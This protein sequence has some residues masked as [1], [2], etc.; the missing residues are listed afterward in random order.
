MLI[1]FQE[2]R[3]RSFGNLPHF[4]FDVFNNSKCLLA[5][6]GFWSRD[7]NQRRHH[8]SPHIYIESTYTINMKSIIFIPDKIL[9][10]LKWA[11]LRCWEV[12][13]FQPFDEHTWGSGSSN[14]SK[15]TIC[16]TQSHKLFS[17]TEH[18]HANNLCNEWK[19]QSKVSLQPSFCSKDLFQN[20]NLLDTNHFQWLKDSVNN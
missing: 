15:N 14:R 12:M 16:R 11:C 19:I 18:N 4:V 8:Y 20:F 10:W 3:Q 13:M 5:P 2:V 6:A 7:Q 1:L 9:S 17:G